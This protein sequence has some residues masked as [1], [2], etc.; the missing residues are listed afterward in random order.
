MQ[1]LSSK[2]PYRHAT[3]V[4]IAS[5]ALLAISCRLKPIDD[6]RSAGGAARI[7]SVSMP[8]PEKLKPYLVDGKIDAWSLSIIGGVCANGAMTPVSHKEKF[9]LFSGS[10][11][12]LSEKITANCAYTFTMSLGKASADKT[13]LEKVYL[14]NDLDSKRT[15][16]T[17]EQNKGGKVPVTIMLYF[18]SDG[19]AALG[20]TSGAPLDPTASNNNTLT[21]DATLNNGASNQPAPAPEPTANATCYKGD[22]VICKIEFL[23]AEKTNEYRKKSGLR[24]LDYDAKIA[25]VARD[26]SKKQSASGSIGHSGFPSS[27]TSVYRQEFGAAPFLT[28]ENVAY[29]YCNA[30][31]EA[32]AAGA[33]I[34][35]WWNSSG[36]RRNML[37]G[38]NAIG[39]G[40]ERDSSGRCYGTQIFR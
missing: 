13:K 3:T 22:S 33:F 6:I 15:E 39:V 21:P 27:R 7:S 28:A 1:N 10:D 25:F 2:L 40:V 31:N 12:L 37:G 38:H 16:I 23:I 19:T 26:W 5:S 35:Q 9:G 29:N 11:I 18:T 34:D 8:V 14:T 4:L 20:A 32:A 36:H 30:G 24:E 17:A